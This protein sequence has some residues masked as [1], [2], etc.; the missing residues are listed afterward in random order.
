MEAKSGGVIGSESER[1]KYFWFLDHLEV[2]RWP[3]QTENPYDKAEEY[4]SLT[5]KIDGAFIQS[6]TGW[7]VPVFGRPDLTL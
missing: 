4:W 2:V 5:F 3:C 7:N 6:L 1:G